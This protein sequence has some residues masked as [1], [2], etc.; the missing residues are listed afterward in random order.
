MRFDTY[1]QNGTNAS[2]SDLLW[3]EHD[4]KSLLIRFIGVNLRNAFQLSSMKTICSCDYR[5]GLLFITSELGIK[6]YLS[7]PFV[8]R[9]NGKK[10]IECASVLIQT[11]V[12]T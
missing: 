3:I 4:V 8:R 10:N 7:K 12:N 1:L 6:R 2:T 5:F 9:D 11:S